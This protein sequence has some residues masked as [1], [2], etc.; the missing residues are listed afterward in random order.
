MTLTVTKTSDFTL[1]ANPTSRDIEPGGTATYTITVNDGGSLPPYT[2]SFPE[3]SV[4]DGLTATIDPMSLPP[5]SNT[6]SVT[7]TVQTDATV[8]EG[9][10]SITVEASGGGHTA[11]VTVTLT[12]N[13]AP[14]LESAG[15]YRG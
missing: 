5:T 7:L 2:V 12:I 11:N 6:N 9:I 10:Y 8:E 1:S 4:T 15:L 14:V 13:E 3:P